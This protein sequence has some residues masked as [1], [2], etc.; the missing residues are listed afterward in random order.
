M[1]R[2]PDGCTPPWIPGVP[3][4]LSTEPG[5]AQEVA[6]RDTP[7]RTQTDRIP[8]RRRC[9]CD[10][11]EVSTQHQHQGTRSRRE[12][13]RVL[14]NRILQ[15]T[16]NTP[17]QDHLW[18]RLT[19]LCA[20]YPSTIPRG[21]AVYLIPRDQAVPPNGPGQAKEEQAMASSEILPLSPPLH[22]TLRHLMEDAKQLLSHLSNTHGK[23]RTKLVAVLEIGL[24][25]VAS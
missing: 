5:A 24:L 21:V 25:Q 10:A 14:S 23:L 6:R 9:P 7:P 4:G 17:I 8:T 3:C 11:V 16:W 12:G 19:F 1:G 20:Y 22:N 2:C 15:R 13:L 18:N